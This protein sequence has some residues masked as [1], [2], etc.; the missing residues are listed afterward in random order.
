ME[1]QI[2]R[3]LCNT[4][5][6][7]QTPLPFYATQIINPFLNPIISANPNKGEEF[8]QIAKSLYPLLFPQYMGIKYCNNLNLQKSPFDNFVNSYLVNRLIK[9]DFTIE[10]Q[11]ARHLC[12]TL[13]MRLK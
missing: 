1:K 2:A 4:A 6:I 10:K 13:N 9:R 5:N 11:I 12:N 7:Y 8:Q 3:H